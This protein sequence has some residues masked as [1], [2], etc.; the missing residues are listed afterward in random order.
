MT[1][2]RLLPDPLQPANPAR[3]L[4]LGYEP[5]VSLNPVDGRRRCKG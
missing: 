1:S 4:S 3:G 5:A 2:T